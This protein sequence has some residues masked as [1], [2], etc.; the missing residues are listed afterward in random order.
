[1]SMSRQINS[2]FAALMITVV[3]AGA[4]LLIVNMAYAT[5]FKIVF[6]TGATEYLYY[7]Q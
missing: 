1:M 2:Y 5:M 6:V 3:G 4:T 7:F